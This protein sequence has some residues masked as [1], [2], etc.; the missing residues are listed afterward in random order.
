MCDDI[1]KKFANPLPYLR[2]GILNHDVSVYTYMAVC[3]RVCYNVN[4]YVERATPPWERIDL[5]VLVLQ[6]YKQLNSLSNV[7][8]STIESLY[9]LADTNNMKKI[10]IKRKCCGCLWL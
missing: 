7:H 8:H 4:Q 9:N 1:H 6:S 2:E 3:V 5:A 10:R